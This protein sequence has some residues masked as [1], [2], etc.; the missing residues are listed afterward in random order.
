MGDT[1]YVLKLKET[2][3]KILGEGSSFLLMQK[4]ELFR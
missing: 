1:I 2:W 4:V 3:T